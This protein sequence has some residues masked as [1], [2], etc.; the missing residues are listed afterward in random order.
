[1]KRKGKEKE[2]CALQLAGLYV[3]IH[4]S[5]ETRGR[6]SD[7]AIRKGKRAKEHEAATHIAAA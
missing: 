4:A 3:A 7:K 6:W 2:K 5:R 1:M